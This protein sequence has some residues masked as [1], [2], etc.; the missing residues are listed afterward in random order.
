MSMLYMVAIYITIALACVVLAM[1]VAILVFRRRSD[2]R[3]Q[4]IAPVR[5]QLVVDLDQ[6]LAGKLA[7]GALAHKL[8][9]HRSLALGLLLAR[10]TRSNEEEQAK[11]HEIFRRMSFDQAAINAL[12]DRHA[13]RR[14]E[15]AMELGYMGRGRGVGGLLRAINDEDGRVRLAAAQGLSQLH[16]GDAALPILRATMGEEGI[17]VSKATELLVKLGPAAVRP[18]CEFLDTPS[19]IKAISP[20]MAIAACNA[21]A[22]IGL[23]RSFESVGR[24][25]DHPNPNV[26]ASVARALGSASNA[27]DVRELLIDLAQDPAWEVRGQAVRAMARLRDSDECSAALVAAAGD[28]SWWVRQNAAHALGQQGRRGVGSLLAILNESPDIYARDAARQVL[29]EKS[30]IRP[31]GVSL[32]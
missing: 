9:A 30:I 29:E 15:G 17:P 21:L 14:A 18:L 27:S 22:L 20:S 23:D 10:A 2:E 28:G 5:D 26:R 13:D 32:Q 3:Q 7:P 16:L 11:L 8:H 19:S 25:A 6:Y 4:K 24:F 31:A 1:A 12:G